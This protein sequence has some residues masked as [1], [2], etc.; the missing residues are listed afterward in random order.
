M[1]S[2]GVLIVEDDANLRDVLRDT[3]GGSDFP[4]RKSVV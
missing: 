2:P 3:L 4:D 1:S